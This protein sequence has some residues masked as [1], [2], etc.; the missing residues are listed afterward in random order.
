MFII[1]AFEFYQTYRK[2][3]KNL[4]ISVKAGRKDKYF[5]ACINAFRNHKTLMWVKWI[6]MWDKHFPVFAFTKITTKKT[7]KNLHIY[8]KTGASDKYFV[9]DDKCELK[10]NT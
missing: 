2:P 9:E 10:K 3:T 6:R 5:F 8:F 1:P 4:L 7:T